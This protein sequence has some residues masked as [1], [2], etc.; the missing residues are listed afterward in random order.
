MFKPTTAYMLVDILHE[1]VESG[2]GT[3]AKIKGM[4]VAGKTGTNSDYGS[5]YF[6]GMTGYYTAVVW[7][8]PDKY[9]YKLPKGSTG[10]KVAAPYGG[11]L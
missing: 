5:A 10:G 2:T 9:E 1:A 8:G 3:A 7:V 6:A 11:R 4:T